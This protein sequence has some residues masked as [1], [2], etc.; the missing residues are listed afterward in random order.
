MKEY[1]LPGG[2][3]H[4]GRDPRGHDVWRGQRS[5]HDPSAHQCPDRDARNPRHLPEPAQLLTRDRG[6][7]HRPWFLLAGSELIAGLQFPFWI[8]FG[9]VVLFT[10]LTNRSRFFRQFYFIGGNHRAAR[11][12]G[13]NADRVIFL[14]FVLWRLPRGTGW[15]ADRLP[16]RLRHRERRHRRRTQGDHRRRA[17]RGG[18]PRRGWLD[19]GR[20]PGGAS[21]SRFIQNVLI[22]SKVPGLLA[23]DRGRGRPHRCRRDRIPAAPACVSTG[24]E[25]IGS[26]STGWACE[27][28]RHGPGGRTVNT[29]RLTSK[30]VA[31]MLVIAAMAAPAIGWSLNRLRPHSGAPPAAGEC[32]EEY[33][34]VGALSTLPLFQ[35]RD[36]PVPAGARRGTRGLR[37]CLGTGHLRC[38]R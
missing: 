7:D 32:Q 8:M 29:R 19:R 9:L 27:I 26:G 37:P 24:E 4:P 10:L 31:A 2:R 11:L 21:S 36:F 25:P 20:L 34:W 6:D 17:R 23:G 30:A 12:F 38:P 14:G 28:S 1:A 15:G 35:A 13:I 22:I 33:V 5:D 16:P 3:G 18:A